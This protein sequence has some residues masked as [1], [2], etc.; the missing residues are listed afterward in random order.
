M[1]LVESIGMFQNH[2]RKVI[3]VIIFKKKK[4]KHL[5]LTQNG[6]K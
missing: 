1:I 3:D 2:P 5:K 6:A 4:F